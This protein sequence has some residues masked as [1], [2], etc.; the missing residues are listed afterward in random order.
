MVDANGSSWR[1]PPP[2][3]LAA[4][5]SAIRPLLGN[6][7]NAAGVNEPAEVSNVTVPVPR[8]FERDPEMRV[9]TARRT[10]GFPR[11]YIRAEE[12]NNWLPGVP[13]FVNLFL[14]CFLPLDKP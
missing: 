1:N 12:P 11:C 4:A 5:L 3:V 14:P 13:R 2:S 9:R 6:I 8:F 10:I 7:I